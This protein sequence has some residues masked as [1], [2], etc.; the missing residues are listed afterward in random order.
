MENKISEQELNDILDR[1]EE[2]EEKEIY[3][4]LMTVLCG[5]LVIGS[6]IKYLF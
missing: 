3:I 5:A 1:R 2:R 4:T 6:I